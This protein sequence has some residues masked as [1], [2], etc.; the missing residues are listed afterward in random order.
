MIIR[1]GFIQDV[2]GNWINISRVMLIEAS[3]SYDG[4]WKI[5]A[6]TDLPCKYYAMSQEYETKE[7]AQ[8]ALFLRMLNS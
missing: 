7:E 2:D 4:K 5:Y 3:V 1:N 8:E 6:V